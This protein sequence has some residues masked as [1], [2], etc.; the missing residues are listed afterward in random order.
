MTKH[1]HFYAITHTIPASMGLYKEV[2]MKKFFSL[3]VFIYLT[4]PLFSQDATGLLSTLPVAKDYVQH[5][6]SSY[7]RSG[8]NADA[9]TIAPGESLTLLDEAGPGLISHVWFT[10]AS[11]DPNHLKALVLRMYWDGE[12]TPSVEAPVGD[13]FGLGL[14]DYHL[15]Q[16]IP[17]SVGSDKAVNCF[18]PMPFQKHA[19]ITVTNEGSIKTDAFYF[20]IDYRAYSKALP[21]DAL[22]FHAQYRQSAPAQG[23]TN[24]WRSNGDPNVNDKKNLNGDGNYVW[25]E[26]TGHGHFV[27][28]T[29]SVL[30]NQDGWWG[31][32]DDMFF[33][34]GEKTPSINGT[35]SEDYFLG[36]WDFGGHALAY[37]LYGAPVVGQEVAG[38]RSSVYR[39]HLDSPIPFTKSLRAT[40]EHG[41]AN[42]RSDNYYSV[43][44]W[45]QS[46]PHAPFPALPGLEQR[47]PRIYAVGGPGNAA[48]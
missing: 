26:A 5:R 12:A 33:V 42:H 46:E 7:D 13:F 34:D 44:Y 23:W 16:S 15:Y 14:G 1:R 28:V 32:G 8:A 35:G 47:I 20:N 40:I 43:A 39:F 4:V 18:F 6:A 2:A 25:M 11:D 45:Y 30:Q 27:G 38:G 31:E 37:G 17:L 24:Q 22:Y 19:R 9:R 36:A 48:K 10:I 21:G 29:M 3:L 41:H